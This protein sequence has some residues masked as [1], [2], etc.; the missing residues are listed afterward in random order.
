ML[1]RSFILIAF[2]SSLNLRKELGSLYLTEGEEYEL[3]LSDYFSGDNLSFS[4]ADINMTNNSARIENQ[5]DFHHLSTT[6][7]EKQEKSWPSWDAQPIVMWQDKKVQAIVGFNQNYLAIYKF[8]VLTEETKLIWS[9]TLSTEHKNS[10]IQAIAQ[11]RASHGDYCLA[12]LI[13]QQESNGLW[14]ND[15]YMIKMQDN[16][17]FHDPEKLNLNEIT[18]ASKIVMGNG[19]SYKYFPIYCEF[20]KNSSIPNVLY[21][22]GISNFQEPILVQAISNYEKIASM[23]SPLSIRSILKAAQHMHILDSNYGVIS[24]YK[25]W[26]LEIFEEE[27]NI[28]LSYF[29][30]LYSMEFTDFG[31]M[32][33]K[34]SSGIILIE[35]AGGTLGLRR[36]W[37]NPEKDIWIQ[38][39]ELQNY[40]FLQST[41][42]ILSIFSISKENQVEV[43]Y[44]INLKSLDNHGDRNIPHILCDREKNSYY[45]QR[46]EEEGL[47]AYRINLK[48]WKLRIVGDLF[49]VKVTA[50]DYDSQEIS[51][52]L[53]VISIPKNSDKIFALEEGRLKV[54]EPID[55]WI[56]EKN[57]M[58]SFSPSTYFSGPNLTYEFIFPLS[59][60]FK[61]EISNLT[62]LEL[63]ENITSPD[64][65]RNFLVSES[66]FYYFYD[67]KIDLEGINYF[68][69]TLNITN[70]IKMLENGGYYA[71][72]S[73]PSENI[74]LISTLL[75]D[76][77]TM[78]LLE[79]MESE[80]DCML[81]YFYNNWL[82]CGNSE[83]INIYNWSGFWKKVFS[84][85]EI[86]DQINFK[87]EIVDAFLNKDNGF[88][89]ILDRNFGV[90]AINMSEKQISIKF[91][92]KTKGIFK[93]LI[94]E[95]RKMGFIYK[96]KFEIYN[97]LFQLEK[98]IFFKAVGPLTNAFV[99]RSIIFIQIGA[100]F[101]VYNPSLLSHDALVYSFEIQD[102]GIISCGWYRWNELLITNY[103]PDAK[104]I[105]IYK[106]S[107]PSKKVF[108]PVYEINIIADDIDSLQS[109][110]Y[111]ENFSVIA[112]NAHDKMEANFSLLLHVDGNFP[113]IE[114]DKLVIHE[115]LPYN[116]R[117]EVDLG[118]SFHGQY[119][120]MSLNIN[121]IN[122]NDQTSE[123]LPA[124][125]PKRVEV[126]GEHQAKNNW[127]KDQIIIPRTEIA[128]IVSEN[129][130]LFVNSTG[131]NDEKKLLNISEHTNLK[132]LTCSLVESFPHT[133]T[134]LSL[135]VTSCTYRASSDHLF[136][137]TV[138]EFALENALILWEIDFIGLKITNYSLFSIAAGPWC[139]K[140]A[141]LTELDFELMV[142]MGDNVISDY[143]DVLRF[144]GK[145]IEN[146]I[147]IQLLETINFLSLDVP[148]FSPVSL[149]Y[150]VKNSQ[151][152]YWYLADKKYGIRVLETSNN[153]KSHLVGELPYLHHHNYFISF[154]I[155]GNILYVSS[156]LSAI[157]S[158]KIKDYIYFEKDSDYNVLKGSEGIYIGAHSPIICSMDNRYFAVHTFNSKSLFLTIFDTK[159]QSNSNL[160]PNFYLSLPNFAPAVLKTRFITENEISAIFYSS[161]TYKRLKVNQ[162][163]LI[164]PSMYKMEYNEMISKWGTENFSITISAENM[165]NA[166]NSSIIYFTREIDSGTLAQSNLLDFTYWLIKFLILIAILAVFAASVNFAKRIG[167]KHKI[168]Q[169]YFDEKAL[170]A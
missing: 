38:G 46:F 128:L 39:Y 163:S 59:E 121:G 50:K 69:I 92:L 52:I 140:I 136:V 74:F 143:N 71:V 63:E 111:Q 135:I 21:I 167:S 31:K 113:W 24:F 103:N 73:S 62:R 20:H 5:C 44:K 14:R 96:D 58:I 13:K 33:V 37:K 89:D 49:Y 148:S 64:G 83:T 123:I 161:F 48:E 149:D 1:I 12:V 168:V 110:W 40:Y 84:L 127:M 77:R 155:C 16:N 35:R 51:D 67:N 75:P 26:P 156:S 53:N 109:S 76:T 169:A 17:I 3:P 122:I 157:V 134:N 4:I 170:K 112:Y 85:T 82:L 132:K 118:D 131:F 72:Y 25:T 79:E 141:P 164:F 158:Y 91:A 78:K 22:Y 166:V 126:V 47:K 56:S 116:N 142:A 19:S 11:L 2:V 57:S 102:P 153:Q 106:S 86:M 42:G 65:L 124:F 54:P 68:R 66:I 87:L 43:T 70:P 101:Y 137:E 90:F 99:H 45:F 146:L 154:G 41:S 61:Y 6:P 138:K 115:N 133:I 104:L 119:L 147:S 10:Q 117:F 125:I 28:N 32:I 8:S 114:N 27:L 23:S 152:S 130:F 18:Y 94:L 144:R 88:I 36:F 107:F 98:T 80:I 100:I 15:I 159:S 7:Y 97:Y 105:E 151:T 93:I 160:Y 9:T 55:L 162:N 165:N 120:N 60:K 150:K 108:P 30:E 139:L 95:E 129:G 29:G 81:F 34:A 145:W